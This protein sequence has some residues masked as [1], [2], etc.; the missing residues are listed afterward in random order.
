MCNKTVMRTPDGGKGIEERCEA[1]MTNNF[2]KL[3][4]DT[5]QQIQKAQRTFSRISAKISTP[6]DIIF[7]LQ[8]IKNKENLL[9]RQR[10]KKLAYRKVGIRVHQI[11]QKSC[12]QGER[13]EIF[14]VLGGKKKK[15]SIQNTVSR[16]IILQK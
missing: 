15:P 7:K 10:E 12:K 16:K 14:K 8:K 5:N 13:L 4:P 6:K 2:P 3:M 9:K 1:I 11:S